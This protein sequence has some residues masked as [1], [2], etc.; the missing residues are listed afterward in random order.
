M[1]RETITEG[2]TERALAQQIRRKMIQRSHGDKKKFTRKV[3][4]RKDFTE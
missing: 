4:H 1:T 2:Y 3:K